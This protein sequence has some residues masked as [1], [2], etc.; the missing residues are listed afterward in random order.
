VRQPK[1]VIWH[2]SGHVHRSETEI[3][4]ELMKMTLDWMADNGLR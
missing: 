1:R 3:V 4:V 2:E